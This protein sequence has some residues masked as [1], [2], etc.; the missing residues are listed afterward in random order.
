[1]SRYRQKT[2]RIMELLKGEYLADRGPGTT[3]SGSWQDRVMARIRDDR[4][5]ESFGFT[6]L[7][8]Q[9]TWRLVPA[10]CS[11]AVLLAILTVRA[12]LAV[13][14]NPYQLLMSYAEDLMLTQLFGS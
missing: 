11:L 3:V 6:T 14:Y 12:H 8:G 1:M 7:L 4:G 10:T 9:I 2:Q 13:G 5:P